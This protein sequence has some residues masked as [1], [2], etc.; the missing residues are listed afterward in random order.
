MK[1]KKSWLNKMLFSYL[2]AFFFI[3]CVLFLISFVTISENIK[4]STVKS[5]QVFNEQISEVI[6]NFLL[7][8][9]QIITN[10]ILINDTFV[11]SFENREGGFFEIYDI[12]NKLNRI[13]LNFPIIDSIYIF[14]QRDQLVLSGNMFIELDDFSDRDFILSQLQERS[15]FSWTG[16]RTYKDQKARES[17]D[18]ISLVR[19][20]PFLSGELGIVVV[21]IRISAI[22]NLVLKMSSHNINFVNLYDREGYMIFSTEEVLSEDNRIQGKEMVRVTSDYSGWELSSG[23][24]DASIFGFFSVFPYF[25]A[26]IGFLSILIGVLWIV[27]VT[28]KSYKPIESIMNRINEVFI[29]KN[30]DIFSKGRQDEMGFISSVIDNLLEESQQFHNQNE[31]DL[32]KKRKHLFMELVEGHRSIAPTEWKSEL[33]R[34]G[35]E[36]DFDEI[37]F[38]I[39]EIDKYPEFSDLY[40][41]QD[42]YLLKF[43]IRSVLNEIAQDQPF[44][45]W[46]EWVSSSRLGILYMVK[47]QSENHN[48]QIPSIISQSCN[49][50]IM[51]VDDNLDFTITIGMTGL[52]QNIENLHQLYEE[53][54][55]TLNY[56]PIM[57]GHQVISY[58][59]IKFQP[60]KDIFNHLQLIRMIAKAYHLGEDWVPLFQR[61]FEEIKLSFLPREDIVSLINYLISFL[62]KELTALPTEILEVW[63]KNALEDLNRL[64]EQFE[65]LDDFQNNAYQILKTIDSDMKSLRDGNANY[66][67]IHKFKEY[68][69]QNYDNSDL[70]LAYLSEVFNLS[71]S[72]LSRLFK[73]EFGEKFVD[74]LARVRMDRAKELLRDTMDPVQDIAIKVGYVH[75]FSF[76]RAFKKVV[77]ITPGDY[78]K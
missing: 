22:E 41:G 45:I 47:H 57:G 12:V 19:K 69:E 73:D 33:N 71:S 35:L 18:V 21:N 25:W 63:K 39:L 14:R 23:I 9:D 55:E 38:G 49:K 34:L 58:L 72:Y 40:S 61:F 1:K 54:L 16:K 26:S 37:S 11:Q 46:S 2:P 17:R 36:E 4:E 27:Y 43:V 10:E 76:I 13:S 66:Q 56:K 30:N 42:Q 48:K 67:L 77:G 5:T 60:Q 28:R 3:S 7:P 70:S 78:R 59:D 20:V 44:S 8:M 31:E 62:D 75:P 52:T 74:Y 32:V 65:T 51:W 6:E 53:A 29:N 64:L 15:A 68:I 50:T 24:K